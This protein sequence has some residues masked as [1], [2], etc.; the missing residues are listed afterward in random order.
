MRMG[1]VFIQ[2]HGSNKDSAFKC[3]VK[4]WPSS[5]HPEAV[6]ILT[7]LL[8]I[9]SESNIR[10]YTDSQSCINNYNHILNKGRKMTV[11]S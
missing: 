4:E 6:A 2:L 8:S 5:S 9:P 7:A 3:R 10:I 11:R 1:I